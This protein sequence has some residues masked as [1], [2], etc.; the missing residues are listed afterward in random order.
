[1]QENLLIVPF[2]KKNSALVVQ[3]GEFDG[4]KPGFNGG[5][6]IPVKVPIFEW[7]KKDVGLMNER[8]W[9]AFNEVEE[10]QERRPGEFLEFE[11]EGYNMEKGLHFFLSMPLGDKDLDELAK[12]NDP[13][14]LMY[15]PG[16]DAVERFHK[17]GMKFIYKL[18]KSLL[19]NFSLSL[20][21]QDL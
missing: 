14:P 18:S 11:H 12:K 19:I 8:Q 1:M 16:P 13:R 4:L 17:P 9:R 6:E 15:I 3:T 7:N 2:L 20:N 10:W 5:Q 21:F